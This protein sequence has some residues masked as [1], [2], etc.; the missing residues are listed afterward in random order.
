MIHDDTQI[1]FR[2]LDSWNL[3]LHHL[4]Y[5]SNN[6]VKRS[7]NNFFFLGPPANYVTNSTW[8]P[9]N[10]ST[11][12]VTPLGATVNTIQH[13]QFGTGWL[14]HRTYQSEYIWHKILLKIQ[15]GQSIDII[16]KW[17]PNVRRYPNHNVIRSVNMRRCIF[18]MNL[19]KETV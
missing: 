19:H 9:S 10:V 6:V 15:A 5:L 17:G 3:V 4:S 12:T 8:S 7:H 18:F 2:F 13:L 16:N 11:P 14:F 1:W